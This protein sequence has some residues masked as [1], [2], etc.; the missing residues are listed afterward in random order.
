MAEQPDDASGPRAEVP[1]PYVNLDDPRQDVHRVRAHPPHQLRYEVAERL[2]PD[3]PLPHV[4][5]LGGGT[6]EFARRL[7]DR[8]LMVTFADLSESN[9]ERANAEGFE[10]HRVDLNFPLPFDDCSFD[11]VTML[12]VIEH[13]VAA[14]RLLAEV[15]RVL[16]P[17]GF[18]VLSTPNF[19][20]FVNRLRILRGRLSVDEGYHYRF[21]N[22]RTLRAMVR[23]AGFGVEE[24]DQT[25]PAFGVNRVSR[26]RGRSLRRHVHVPSTFASVAAQTL[27]MRARKA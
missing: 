7:R 3:G 2:I 13:I 23:D 1:S 6:G 16:R 14:E 10:T 21:F 18:V 20:F 4:L 12:E 19:S 11:G 25:M 8:G 22:P 17:N 15:H 24:T 9:V 27:F 26:L 5:E